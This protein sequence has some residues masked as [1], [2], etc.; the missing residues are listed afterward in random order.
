MDETGKTS[1]IRPIRGNSA[2]KFTA[3]AEK[4][5][6]AVVDGNIE[7]TTVAHQHSHHP[8]TQHHHHKHHSNYLHHH[9]HHHHHREKD[10]DEDP[11]DA[12][13]PKDTPTPTDI[14]KVENLSINNHTDTENQD[15]NAYLNHRNG[16]AT[17]EP[18]DFKNELY[19][20][21][22]TIERDQIK[23]LENVRDKIVYKDDK[24]VYKD[25]LIH[26]EHSGHKRSREDVDEEEINNNMVE[27]EEYGESHK[28]YRAM[29]P[30]YLGNAGFDVKY[31]NNVEANSLNNTGTPNIT[32]ATLESVAN[33]DPPS[34]TLLPNTSTEY[35]LSPTSSII[36]TNH[37][38]SGGSP[39]HYQYLNYPRGSADGGQS[40]QT[41]SIY[42]ESPNTSP[43][44]LQIYGVHGNSG[45]PNKYPYSIAN[46]QLTNYQVTNS[47]LNLNK[48]AENYWQSG[49]ICLEYANGSANTPPGSASGNAGYNDT[50]IFNNTGNWT[51]EYDSNMMLNMDIKEC[52]N[53]AA[54]STPLWRRDGTGHHLCNACGLYNRINGVNR[55]PVRT[56]QKKA[57]QQTG[58]KRSG[59]SCANCSTT[60]TTLWR[61]NNNGE[62][63]CN[64]CGLYF[65][66]HNVNR[67]LSMKK[68]SIQNRKRK[69]KN[70]GSSMSPPLLK[71]SD[72]HSAR[73]H[74]HQLLT[75]GKLVLPHMSLG[76][77][78]SLVNSEHY[79]GQSPFL[80]SSTSLL[81]RHISSMPPIESMISRN[82]DAL[83]V[84]TSTP[85]IHHS[86]D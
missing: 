24:I 2:E 33:G 13:P 22:N 37:T 68:E 73:H 47:N 46:E 83:S 4:F 26:Y 49:N 1:V 70:P 58:N 51:Q 80:L 7:N 8:Q 44:T 45:I 81:N 30:A 84:I 6:G 38:T 29:N 75:D 23:D 42:Y 20:Y 64:A 12:A 48:T 43:N 21:G 18:K 57:L 14:T 78:D 60:C 67:P 59:V 39:S 41:A 54:N 69:P 9:H 53:C 86:D 15:A 77:G 5:T 11:E 71:T 25:E 19:K 85:N 63:V 28:K 34:G 52:V 35:H 61:R 32:Y 56:N 16:E 82:G 17:N 74:G 3:V 79:I 55:P 40:Q 31:E 66:L 27:G 62:P 50:Y 72:H 65:K 76:P 10:P 36:Y